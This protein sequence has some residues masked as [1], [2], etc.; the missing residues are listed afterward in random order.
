MGSSGAFRTKTEHYVSAGSYAH[1]LSNRISYHLNL[2]GPSLTVE[3]ACSSSF[4]AIHLARQA[5]LNGECDSALAGGVNL[6]FHRS[7]YFMLSQ[8]GIISPDGKERTFD[9]GANGYV[10]GEGVGLVMLKRYGD[11]LKDGDQVYGV[12]KGSANNHSGQ[13]A[14]KYIPNFNALAAASR[15]AIHE[16]GILPEVIDYI[17]TH[18]TGTKLE[19]L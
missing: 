1:E 14:G 12:I 7:K 13:G 5:I 16:A 8:L 2:R 4:T 3:T 6:N 11:A 19:I 9:E 15:L 10:P 17:E 18:G